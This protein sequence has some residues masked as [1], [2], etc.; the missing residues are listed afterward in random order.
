MSNIDL[1]LIKNRKFETVKELNNFIKLINKHFE[2][3]N[4][5]EL[6]SDLYSNIMDYI[7]SSIRY[8]DEISI[9]ACTE[10]YLLLYNFFKYTNVTLNSLQISELL[11]ASS[12]DSIPIFSQYVKAGRIFNIDCTKNFIEFRTNIF[13]RDDLEN[14]NDFIESHDVFEADI[15]IIEKACKKNLSKFVSYQINKKI[16]L[17]EQCL[18]NSLENGNIELAKKILLCDCHIDDNCLVSACKSL[19]YDAILF[20]INNGIKPNEKCFNA[21]ISSQCKS[22]EKDVKTKLIDVIIDHGYK[23]TYDNVVSATYEHITINNLKNMNITFNDDFSEVCSKAK[24]YVYDFIVKPS[25]S[26]LE[27]ACKIRD[28]KYI[29]QLVSFGIKP[30][31]TCL[32]NACSIKSN[33]PIIKFIIQKGNL[34]PDIICLKNMAVATNNT[35]MNYLLDGFSKTYEKNIK[36]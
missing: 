31:I 6:P 12:Y 1:S 14:I 24:F 3:N 33:L 5:S 27:E 18:Y 10:L 9:L 26:D 22:N 16:K 29:K 4:M 28:L 25:I 36:K 7:M 13:I 8:N 34:E 15:E 30:N 2:N 32:R 11:H 19:N 21:I 20:V 17:S 23:I 35:A